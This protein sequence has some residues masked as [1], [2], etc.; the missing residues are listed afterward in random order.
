MTAKTKKFFDRNYWA[1]TLEGAAFIGGISML[2]SGGVIA[3]F[4]DTMTGSKTLVGLAITIQSFFL[5]AGQLLIAPQ[6]GAIKDIP[7]FMFKVMLLRV[8]PIL[9]AVPLFMGIGGGLAVGIFL[10]LLGLFWLSDGVNTVPWGELSA[11]A[12]RPEL[13]GHMMGMQVVIG[14]AASLLTGLL[15]TWLLATPL[16]TDNY[17][18][19]VIFVISGVIFLTSLF[20]IRMVKDPSPITMPKKPDV[21]SYYA[22]IPELIKRSKP[23]QHALI[24]RIPGYI[25]FSTITF[26]VV[27]G[28]NVL[29]ISDAQISWLVYSQI[30]GSL[31]GGYV[32]GEASRRM[33]NKAVILMCNF[34][35]L[36]TLGMAVSLAYYPALGYIWL[37]TVCAFA[38]LWQNNWLGYFNYFL[39]IAPRED[40]P[41]FQVIGG[42]IGLPF[43]F[44]GYA[45]G[46][47]IDEWGFVTAFVAGGVA[48]VV[49]IFASV[50]LLSRKS[51]KA[52]N[53]PL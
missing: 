49:T 19:G 42:C 31:I 3:L 12:I 33:G 48:A 32:L 16:L 38:S 36:L 7:G 39:D 46:A 8:I 6:T 45:L 13:R 34:G 14:G 40:R 51:I 29:N 26:L 24:A 22:K 27:F 15:L 1:M 37:I 4:I 43:S 20:F 52:L 23:L 47:A 17:R 35:V 41:A 21:R 18:F 50:R 11:R 2:S 28:A 44:V 5:L 53:L 30:V 9:M 10:V 25:G